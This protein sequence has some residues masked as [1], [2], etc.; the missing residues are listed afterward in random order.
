MRKPFYGV[1]LAPTFVLSV[2][3][4][5]HASPYELIRPLAAFTLAAMAVFVV[6]GLLTRRWHAASLLTT[7]GLMALVRTE[8][9]L[10]VLAWLGAAWLSFRRTGEWGL[11]PRF[12]YPLN[13][14]AAAWF[15]VALATAIFV[16]MPR[17]VSSA[18]AATINPGSN[19]YL[20][21]LDGYPRRDSLM[22]YFGFDNGP[23]LK[24]LEERGFAVSGNSRSEYPSSIQT[25]ATMLHG[26]PLIDLLP[27]EWTGSHEQHRH[28]WQLINSSPIP[29]AY[30]AA[31]YTT[32]SIVSPA[33]GHDWRTADVVL[34]SPWTTDFEEHL[35]TRGLLRLVMPY[36]AM[37]R[38]EMLDAFR[39]LEET[40]GT[41]PRFVLAHIL[42][43][44]SP[45]V[46]A[47]DGSPADR[48][49]E[50][51]RN[52][53]GPPNE[54]LG[55]RLVGQVQW[56]NGMVL[57][58]VDRIIREDPGA[59]VVVFSDHGLRRDRNDMDEWFRTLFAAR[60]SA[61]PDD[62]STSALLSQLQ[63][64]PAAAPTGSGPQAP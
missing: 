52:H 39:F 31:G 9:I 53:A 57:H 2:W 1:L 29:A 25:M 34:D 37:H 32:Y 11:A 23:F 19:V 40:A 46:F 63:G 47:A 21:W 24:E 10:L 42:K 43:P 15:T 51:C 50:P 14:F 64:R 36:A 41:S 55:A 33:P 56:L 5:Q 12:T 16:S 59:T 62:I 60:G 18:P 17:P 13:A 58:A 45:Y 4:G 49:G 61:F 26:R 27:D 48:C 8:L 22:E 30:E 38:A 20:I 6:L 44:H 7:F 54:I 28:L 3:A 35:L